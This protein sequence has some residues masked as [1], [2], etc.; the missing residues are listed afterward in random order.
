MLD[1]SAYICLVCVFEDW[2]HGVPYY[3]QYEYAFYFEE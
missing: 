1:Y 3:E 2:G